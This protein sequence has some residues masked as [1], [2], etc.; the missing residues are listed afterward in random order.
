MNA[1]ALSAPSRQPGGAVAPSCGTRA[2]LVEG[3][4]RGDPRAVEA[5]LTEQGPTLVSIARSI[6]GD[7]HQAMDAVQDGVISA[8]RAIDALRD[9]D[10]LS[11]WLR[12]TVTN[13][14]LAHLRKRKRRRERAIDDYLP[15]YFEDGHRV[16]PRAPWSADACDPEREE[17][18]AMVREA[19]EE[20]P[21]AY[22]EVIMLRDMLEMD[23][24]ETARVLDITFTNVKVRLHRA[25][26]ALRT[27][28][29]ERLVHA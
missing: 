10:A 1:N 2:D 25:R 26:Q 3:L 28:L 15:M 23:T 22:R 24:H 6:L 20:L 19:I 12:K 5:L 18:R 13:A 8:L 7:E 16:D 9:A 29:E 14:A 11:A 4:R 21:A 27:I 17:T